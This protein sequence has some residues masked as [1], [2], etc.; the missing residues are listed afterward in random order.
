MTD[1]LVALSSNL[2]VSTALAAT[3]WLTQS[4]QRLATLAH[5]LWTLAL[6]KLMTPPLLTLPVLS[7]PTVA[8]PLEGA[9]ATDMSSAAAPAFPAAGSAVALDATAALGG[10]WLLGSAVVLAWSLLRIARFDRLLRRS[11]KPATETLEPQL[12]ALC[13]SL[14][15]KRPPELRLT[16]ARIT[17]LVWWIGGRACVYVPEPML[18]AMPGQQV[19]WILAHELAHV[20]RGGELEPARA[21]LHLGLGNDHFESLS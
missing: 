7:A 21:G 3:A 14:G 20:R 17:P 19:R 18:R 8:P 6:V 16:T 12:R 9:S 13:S 4:R 1:L 5:L 15:L 10:A 11:S 2:A